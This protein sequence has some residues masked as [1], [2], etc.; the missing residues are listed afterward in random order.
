MIMTIIQAIFASPLAADLS[1][2]TKTVSRDR[3]FPGQT[4]QYTVVISNSGDTAVQDVLITDTLPVSLTYAPNSLAYTVDNAVT[5]GIGESNGVISWTGVI[6]E[7]GSATLYYQAVLTDTLV[8]NDE[9]I[10]TVYITGTGSLIERTTSTTI[11]TSTTSYFPVLFNP[12]P[13]PIMDTIVRTSSSNVWTVSWDEPV[14]GIEGYEL[15]EDSDSYFNSPETFDVGTDLS[16]EFSPGASVNPQYCYRVRARVGSLYSSWSSAECVYGNYYDDFSSSSTGWSIRREDTD[17]VDNDSYYKNG[18]FVTK[19][20][21]RWDFAVAAPMVEAPGDSYQIRT[22]ALFG[23]GVD[24]LHSYGIIFGGDWNGQT[25]PNSDFS[26]CF[27]HYYR[28]NI[29]YYADD[30]NV[31]RVNLKRIDYHDEDNGAGR[32]ITLMGYKDVKVADPSSWNEWKITV[33]SD[34]SIGIYVNG[35]LVGT[36]NDSTYIHEPYFGVFAASNEYSGT[37]ATFDWYEVKYLP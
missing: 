10:N 11:I 20:R 1:G 29:I 31:L 15:Q 30:A 5:T 33:D 13:T 12:V 21:G 7:Q 3:A 18:T 34:G 32:G 2:S 26:S 22:R 9:I 17:D 19:I 23:D 37:A 16:R 8:A 25:C 27:N 36:A 14:S 4:L 35:S 24:N 28:V 6:S